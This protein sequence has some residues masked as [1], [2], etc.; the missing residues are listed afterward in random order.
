MD[1]DK[2]TDSVYTFTYKVLDEYC[3]EGLIPEIVSIGNESVWHRFMPNVPESEL[4][5]YDPARSVALHNAGSRA[6]R[7]IAEKYGNQYQSLLSHDRTTT[8]PSGG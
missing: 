3:R 2:I 6:V 7:D 1:L 4:P 8:R 5:A